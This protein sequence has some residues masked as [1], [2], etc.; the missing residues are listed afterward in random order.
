MQEILKHP[1]FSKIDIKKLLNFE[2]DPPYKPTIGENEFFD[3]KLVKQ[4]EFT[5]TVLD[6]KA[7]KLVNNTA[8]KQGD[9]FEG[10]SK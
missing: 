6:E 10:F 5:D 9:L 4:T 2:V 7:A 1:F 8:K 3:P